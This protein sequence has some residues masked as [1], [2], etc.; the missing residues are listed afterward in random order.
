M[1][2]SVSHKLSQ[3]LKVRLHFSHKLSKWDCHSIPK[4]W[5]HFESILEEQYQHTEHEWNRQKAANQEGDQEGRVKQ[6]PEVIKLKTLKTRRTNIQ[7][8]IEQALA[9]GS[10]RNCSV[11]ANIDIW[12][13]NRVT[14]FR[15]FRRNLDS[16][17]CKNNWQRIYKNTMS[18]TN[19]I[20]YNEREI[21]DW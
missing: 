13:T 6:D 18:K 7:K 9:T 21:S 8:Q 14:V 20:Q 2:L 11:C 19:K 12:C 17:F 4:F 5:F 10:C 15:E 16:R 1:K 3:L